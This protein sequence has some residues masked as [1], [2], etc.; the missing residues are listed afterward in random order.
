MS[1]RNVDLSDAIYPKAV[2]RTWLKFHVKFLCKINSKIM[3]IKAD[4]FEI[5][6]EKAPS[7]G[8]GDRK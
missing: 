2:D 3:E 1:I 7:K 8:W 4:S 6:F 5:E